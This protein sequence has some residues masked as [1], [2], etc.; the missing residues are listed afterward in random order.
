MVHFAE[1]IAQTA[2]QRGHADA[3]TA[4]PTTNAMSARA[5]SPAAAPVLSATNGGDRLEPRLGQHR[6]SAKGG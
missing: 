2:A 3:T 1:I 5:K 6:G 4:I